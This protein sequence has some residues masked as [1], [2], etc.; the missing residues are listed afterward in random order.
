MIKIKNE[1]TPNVL[2]FYRNVKNK[3]LWTSKWSIHVLDY[4]ESS[5]SER[6]LTRGSDMVFNDTP[7]TNE[8]SESSCKTADQVVDIVRSVARGRPEKYWHT[9]LRRRTFP[10][11]I[12]LPS[13]YN[14]TTTQTR[15][16]EN[17]GIPTTVLTR[18]RSRA[19]RKYLQNAPFTYFMLNG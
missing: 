8:L 3:K 11:T 5:G 2:R 19:E 6:V 16:R 13:P 9:C 14:T 10:H 17:K 15:A 18:Q 12:A 7:V 4:T 1:T